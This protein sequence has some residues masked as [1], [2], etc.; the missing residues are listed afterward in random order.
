MQLHLHPT[1]H[2]ALTASETTLTRWSL[3]TNPATILAQLST[4]PESVFS[5][6]YDQGGRLHASGGVTGSPDGVLFA[7]EHLIPQEPGDW[8]DKLVIDWRRWDDFSLARI[9]S[10]PYPDG[11]RSLVSSPGSLACSPDGRWLVIGPW[12]LGRLF[13]LDW[14]T[15]QI[16]SHHAT[17]GTT[18]ALAFDPT[19]TYVAG[20]ACHDNWG[21]CMLWRLDL[22]E[23]FVPRPQGW[24]WWAQKTPPDEVSGSMALSVVHWELDR[25]GIAWPDRDLADAACQVVF[26][27]DSRMVI[28]NPMNSASSGCGLE[29]V[30]Y[31]V[32]SGKRLWWIREQAENSGAFLFSPDGQRV[33]VPMQNGNLLV[34]RSEDGTLLQQLSTHLD[35]TVQALA[36]DHDS[37]TLW[38]AT[39]GRL[40]QYQSQG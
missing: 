25:T 31:A 39:E 40:I 29:L 12:P 11:I 23:R 32:P 35:E 24:Q 2:E 14:Q 17:A 28:F 10:K 19:S 33:L 22:V 38:L 9:E 6:S 7:H 1:R 16:I 13:L 34:Y 15:G 36:F 30:A 5:L 26:S 4:T 21:H 20:F 37:T 27:P 18:K 8:G 3:G